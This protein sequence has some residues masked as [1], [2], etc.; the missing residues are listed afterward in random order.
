MMPT[1]SY[2]KRA[3]RH[4]KVHSYTGAGATVAA[5]NTKVAPFDDIRV[6][7]ALVTAIIKR[8]CLKR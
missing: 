1:T 3:I 7:R 8:R 4:F 5:F 2:V 6:R